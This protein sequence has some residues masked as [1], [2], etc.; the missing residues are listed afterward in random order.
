MT[1]IAAPFI[2]LTTAYFV[3]ST[4]DR[5][6][7]VHRGSS[8]RTTGRSCEKSIYPI[9]DKDLPVYTV[10]L[11]VFDKPD[12][13]SLLGRIRQIDYPSDRLDIYVVIDDWV[14][15]RG[16]W[17]KIAAAEAQFGHNI[18]LVVLPPDLPRL[19]SAACNH[20][21]QLPGE[22]GK[23]VL[24]LDTDDVPDRLQ[25]RKAASAFASAPANVAA[26]QSRRSYRNADESL[27]TRWLS[28][29]C[30]RW[31]SYLLP[32]LARLNCV[33]PLSGSSVHI[34]VSALHAVGGWDPANGANELDLGIR[35]ARNGYRTFILNSVTEIKAATEPLDWA[36]QRS[37]WCVRSWQ[38]VAVHARHP[39][40]LSRELG[41][42]ALIRLINVTAGWPLWC[43]ANMCFWA[44][45]LAW[46]LGRPTFGS[47]VFASPVCQVSLPLFLAG[48]VIA[49]LAGV[50]T[51]RASGKRECLSAAVLFP[52]YW[53]LQAVTAITAVSRL[54]WEWFFRAW[55][56]RRAVESEAP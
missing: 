56:C 35:F 55:M 16:A 30:D 7:L 29:E 8:G 14:V 20:A 34:R 33:V 24:V 12:F 4:I 47:G 23:Y 46:Y 41:P 1:S 25:L 13:D 54:G 10:L 31:Y 27:L 45:F 5:A 42:S 52:G 51:A 49:L 2:A 17:A 53:L 32:A 28:L 26:L 36:R 11:P 21:M 39:I 43:V 18:R 15:T 50:T 48:N 40:R 44:M 22:R 3:A 38:T 9:A 19:R 6:Y 37:R